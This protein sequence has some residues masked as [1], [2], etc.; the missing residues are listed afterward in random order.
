M[1]VDQ[2]AFHT[3]G[4]FAHQALKNVSSGIQ[5]VIVDGMPVSIGMLSGDASLVAHCR[6]AYAEI[7]TWIVMATAVIRAEFPSWEILQSFTPFNI[8]MLERFGGELQTK[9]Q[10]LA[11]SFN[12]P[13]YEL[14]REYEVALRVAQRISVDEPHLDNRQIWR[15]VVH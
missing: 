11:S 7:N 9:L 6:N 12:L 14:H 8:R 1:F 2:R 3:P 10:R 4:M 13:Q 15:K 5:T